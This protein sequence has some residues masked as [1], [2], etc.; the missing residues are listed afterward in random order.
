V[1]FAARDFVLR[2]YPLALKHRIK[3]KV[4]PAPARTTKTAPSFRS[5]RIGFRAGKTTTK[6]KILT[7]LRTALEVRLSTLDPQVGDL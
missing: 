7:K 1:N 2:A 3:S 5:L 4:F 6:V